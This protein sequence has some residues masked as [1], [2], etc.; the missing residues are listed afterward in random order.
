MNENC[1]KPDQEFWKRKLSAYLHDPPDKCFDI[2]KHE[3]LADSYFTAAG[4]NDADERRAL[5]ASVKAT[6]HFAAAAERFVFPKRKCA[7]KFTGKSGS[8]F[9]HP[10]SSAKFAVD[11]DLSQKAGKF[12][13]ILADALGGI[14]SDDYH[15]KFFLF[16][17][18]WMENAV[19]NDERDADNLA[20]L[21]ADTRIPDHSIWNHIALA[22]ALT[23]CQEKDGND[24]VALKPALLLFQ[25]GP[26]QA[27]IEQARSTRDLWS[28]SYMLSWLMAHAMK[29]V[30]DEIGPDSIIF[31]SLRGNGIFDALHKEEM[32]ST[33][34][35]DADGA[36]MSTWERMIG[37]KNNVEK[38]R[39]ARWL[40]T[41][42][43]PNRFLALVPESRAAE[44]AEKAEL[45]IA[46]ELRGMGDA[47][48]EWIKGE[49]D[50]AGCSTGDVGNWRE[51]W[52]YQIES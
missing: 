3:E 30:S 52:D 18:R 27:F 21:P 1:E 41:P 28:G 48:W 35:D 20:L 31:P 19:T 51:R 44:L 40:L 13:E 36:T 34:W 14:Q 45:A 10:L 23:G 46:A 25:L 39:A 22:S 8:C 12:H 4:L 37:E 5:S 33:L 17:R 26:V 38:G 2:A 16:W 43:L 32:Y 11:R 9:I 6:D 15:K 7:T 50:N 29:A 24:A 49:A 47:V 42:T